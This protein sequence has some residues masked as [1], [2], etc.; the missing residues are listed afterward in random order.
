MF[1]GMN[2]II[3]I[4]GNLNLLCCLQFYMTFLCFGLYMQI[5]LEYFC[6]ILGGMQGLQGMMKQ[7]QQGAAG[8][9]G[10]MFGGK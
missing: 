5:L 2:I 9:M 4:Q 10:N 7:F 1:G 3:K 8:K 6:I